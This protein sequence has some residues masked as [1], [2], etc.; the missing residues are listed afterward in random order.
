[1]EGIIFKGQ[2]C[3]DSRVFSLLGATECFTFYPQV[4]PHEGHFHPF[5]GST[6]FG[7]IPPKLGLG[8]KKRAS[9]GG[10]AH[11]NFW[12]KN[13]TIFFGAK[14]DFLI[15]ISSPLSLASINEKTAY[16]QQKDKNTAVS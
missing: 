14:R 12:V 1:M 11:K 3:W 16:L 4:G 2:C 7:L 6:L 8:N 10:G 5:G 9:K 13:G 15:I